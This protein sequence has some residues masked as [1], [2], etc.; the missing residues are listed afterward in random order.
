M[1]PE[2][3]LFPNP[4]DGESTPVAVSGELMSFS[5]FC[6][7][8]TDPTNTGRINVYMDRFCSDLATTSGPIPEGSPIVTASRGLSVI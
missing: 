8:K 5:A 1:G 4:S 6:T 7:H 3:D 2:W